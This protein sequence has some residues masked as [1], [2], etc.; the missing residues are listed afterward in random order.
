MMNSRLV[1]ALAVGLVLGAVLASV[2]WQQAQAQRQ[3]QVKGPQWEYKVTSLPV[4]AGEAA[5]QLNNLADE[6]WE[7]VGLVNTSTPRA[8]AGGVA[9]AILGHE[10]LVAFKRPKK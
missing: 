3:V 9:P 2:G 6:G 1:V 7:Y 8:Q 10:S 5:K 4:N